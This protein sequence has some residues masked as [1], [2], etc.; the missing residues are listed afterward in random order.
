[1]SNTETPKESAGNSFWTRERCLQILA[2]VLAVVISALIFTFRD[3]LGELGSYGYL[4][5][6]L[7]SMA[8]NATIGLPMPG[9]IIIATLGS[10]MDPYWVGFISALGGTV[11]ELT[12]YLLGYGG[13]IAIQNMP[14]YQRM[15]GWVNRRGSLVIFLLALIPNPFFDVAG[16]AAGALKF[17]VWKFLVYGT[18][19]RI[20]KHIAFAMLGGWGINALNWFQ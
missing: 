11:G 18:L 1:M 20:P 6:F 17:P 14:M 15:V 19:G 9:W 5:V 3:R 16:T 7:I 2:I 8:A 10:V 4:G 13:R 12:G